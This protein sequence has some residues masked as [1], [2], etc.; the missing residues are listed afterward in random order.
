MLVYFVSICVPRP[1]T[2]VALHT[3]DQSRQGAV[4]VVHP[5]HPTVLVQAITL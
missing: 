1:K 2:P 3:S 4:A 5:A